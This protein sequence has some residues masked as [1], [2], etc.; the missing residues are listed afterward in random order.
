MPIDPHTCSIGSKD[1]NSTRQG[2]FQKDIAQSVGI[3]SRVPKIHMFHFEKLLRRRFDSFQ[4][5]RIRKLEFEIRRSQ[6]K[7]MFGL[8]LTF[9]EFRHFALV[10]HKFAVRTPDVA[11]FI[12]NNIRTNLFHKGRVVRN[13]NDSRIQ[14]SCQVIDKPINSSRVQVV[15]ARE[16]QVKAI[17]DGCKHQREQNASTVRQ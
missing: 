5:T 10:V 16:K 7:V 6:F 15:S 17:D 9:D 3:R 12:V 14:Q 8:W 2:H 11:L 13:S 1:G 4:T